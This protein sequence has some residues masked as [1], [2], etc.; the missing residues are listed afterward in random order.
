MK[1]RVNDAVAAVSELIEAG[2]THESRMRDGN[3]IDVKGGHVIAPS[4]V[5]IDADDLEIVEARIRQSNHL[6][7]VGSE[8]HTQDNKTSDM[9][10]GLRK[11]QRAAFMAEPLRYILRFGFPDFPACPFGQSF[12][13]LGYDT[14]KREYVWLAT[15]IL[16]DERLK[17]IQFSVAEHHEAA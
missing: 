9:R 4:Q 3:Q 7:E 16:R 14:E 11:V 12:T 1:V 13:M 5:V 10:Y 2:Y 15:K 8:A 6:N 17:R